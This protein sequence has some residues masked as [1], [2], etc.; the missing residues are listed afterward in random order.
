MKSLIGLCEKSA[1]GNNYIIVDHEI[2]LGKITAE[3]ENIL[4]L[5]KRG[6]DFR[7]GTQEARESD[8][9]NYRL[10]G[11]IKSPLKAP[12]GRVGD[13]FIE[14]CS[15][16]KNRK[17]NIMYSHFRNCYNDAAGN[18]WGDIAKDGYIKGSTK[19]NVLKYINYVFKTNYTKVE[20]VEKL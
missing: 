8:L 7:E 13:Y 18:C 15:N 1:S 9:K 2:E 10:C 12:H 14:I 5:E 4:K 6:G 16:M 19:E 11:Y 17:F 20:I 3:K